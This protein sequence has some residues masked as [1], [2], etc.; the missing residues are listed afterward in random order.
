MDPYS[1][2]R[3]L[4]GLITLMMDT[5]SYIVIIIDKSNRWGK[6]FELQ[7]INLLSV[8]VEVGGLLSVWSARV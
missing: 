4:H 3:T 7:R 8:I 2:I 1:E 5:F 6:L